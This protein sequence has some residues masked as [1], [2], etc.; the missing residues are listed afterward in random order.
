MTENDD[1]CLDNQDISDNMKKALLAVMRMR[2]SNR[3]KHGVLEKLCANQSKIIDFNAQLSFTAANQS[4][5]MNHTLEQ[6]Y[7]YQLMKK[8]EA[9]KKLYLEEVARKKTNHGIK[10]SSASE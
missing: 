2:S 8:S 3:N 7:I 6:I 1:F 9:F 4:R 10:P 5:K